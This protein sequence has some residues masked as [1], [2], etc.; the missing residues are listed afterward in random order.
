MPKR[1][2]TLKIVLYKI[3][4]ND[5]GILLKSW[6]KTSATNNYSNCTDKN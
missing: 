3:G 6:S 5:L 2:K 4:K 1:E